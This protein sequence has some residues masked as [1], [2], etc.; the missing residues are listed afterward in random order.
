MG[1]ASMLAGV[2]DHDYSRT[3]T[4]VA[5]SSGDGELYML[6]SCTTETMGVLQ[7]LRRV[8]RQDSQLRYYGL[9]CRE[10]HGLSTRRGSSHQAHPATPLYT[11][12]LIAAG[13]VRLRNA[14][15][16]GNLAD[17]HTKFF[18]VDRL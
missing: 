1:C 15:T 16:K 12:G 3:Q 18:S 4:T 13:V 8:R 7:F 11:N 5:L 10:V 14:P 6:S 2:A 9:H 17:L